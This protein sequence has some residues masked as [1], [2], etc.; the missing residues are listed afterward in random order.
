LDREPAQWRAI[1]NLIRRR[2]SVSRVATPPLGLHAKRGAPANTRRQPPLLVIPPPPAQLS[3]DHAA[4]GRSRRAFLS[5]ALSPSFP[6]A[7]RTSRE[8]EL[9]FQRRLKL[10][11]KL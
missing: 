8:A 1:I 6:F 4:A 3:A 7:G 5:A 11:V 10:A 9:L 2:P